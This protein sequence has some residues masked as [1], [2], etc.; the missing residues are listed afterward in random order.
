MSRGSPIISLRVPE[1]LLRDVQ[2][3]V[4]QTGAKC[5]GEPWN[6]TSWI[7]QAIRDK[8]AHQQRAREASK[9]RCKSRAKEE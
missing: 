5:Q 1:D 3:V 2:I 4:H 7:L 8:L 9:R 6:L